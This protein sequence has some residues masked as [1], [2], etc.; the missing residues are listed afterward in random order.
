VKT[1]VSLIL[2]SSLSLALAE[3]PKIATLNLA[4][5][6]EKYH[7]KIASEKELKERITSIQ[8]TPRFAAVQEMN[9]KL[10]ELAKTVRTPSHSIEVRDAAALEFNATSLEHQSLNKELETFLATEKKAATNA[11]VTEL[12]AILVEIRTETNN[13]AVQENYDLV[14]EVGGQTSSQTSPIIYLREKTDITQMVLSNLNAHS[15][16]SEAP[17]SE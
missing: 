9:A 10:T 2:L 11:M 1:L 13:I 5:V 17:A 8:S 3:K 6:L 7:R 4:E 14:L 15:P 16:Q 12:E